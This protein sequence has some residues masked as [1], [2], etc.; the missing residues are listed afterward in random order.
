M[1]RILI[2]SAVLTVLGITAIVVFLVKTANSPPIAESGSST[3]REDT[4]GSITLA[5]RDEDGD[6][7]VYSV[8]TRPTHGQLSGTAPELIYIPGT[9]FHGLDSFTFKVNDGKVDSKPATI[10]ITVEPVNDQPKANDDTLK[11]LEDAPVATIDVLANDTD[12][13]D[14]K[15]V[16]VNATQGENGSVNIGADSTLVYTP[17]RNFSGT[18][19][20]KYTLSDGKGG[21][22]TATVSVTVEPVNDAPSITSRPVE[23][24]RVWAS[25]TYDVEAKDPDPGDSL[26][27]SLDGG[28]EGMTI[29]EETGLIEWRPTSAQ[30]GTYNLTV[31]VVDSYKIRAWDT[32][33][34]KLTV[35]SLSSP[36]KSTL[37]VV[38]CFK[39]VG[40][41]TLSARDKIGIVE[42]SDDNHVETE[43]RS[44]TCYEFDNASIPAGASIISVVVYVE[45]FEDESFSDGKLKWAL[46][47]GWPE[48]PAVWVSTIAPVHRGSN[49]EARDFWDV[50]SSVNSPGKANSLHLQ[51][52][53]DARPGRKTAV[54]LVYAVVKWY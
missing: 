13:D 23:T 44:Y 12:P 42:A 34:F 51:V 9:N 25:Y 21:T 8:V 47:T 35:T 29:D 50:T 37:A 22:D 33:T 20:F 48:K 11:A 27:Y 5:G 54:D 4:P 36:L 40:A 32:Q 7:I 30:A 16:V 39:R 3:T 46:G 18:D 43:P 6:Q 28:P 24:T 41:E 10:T 45:H 17:G 14:E 15:L 52:A 53:N 49:N 2:V 31:K 19:I 26:L 38:N 1:K